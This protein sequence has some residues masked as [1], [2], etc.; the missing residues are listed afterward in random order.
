V[1]EI[2][3]DLNLR[4][5]PNRLPRRSANSRRRAR[6]VHGAEWRAR[7]VLRFWTS[8][9]ADSRREGKERKILDSQL[10]KGFGSDL[11][12]VLWL[13]HGFSFQLL[14]SLRQIDSWLLN[15]ALIGV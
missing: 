6:G 1:T 9:R 14:S 11:G 3:L 15:S 7:Y 13:A 10:S 2:D 12:F 5:K 4:A 8:T